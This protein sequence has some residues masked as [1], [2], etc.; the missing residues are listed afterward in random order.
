MRG[1]LLAHEHCARHHPFVKR[2][3][4]NLR[5]RKASTTLNV[6]AVKK[7]RVLSRSLWKDMRFTH[8]HVK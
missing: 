3:I 4:Q 8:T 7:Q 1:D 6:D 5:Y 2:L